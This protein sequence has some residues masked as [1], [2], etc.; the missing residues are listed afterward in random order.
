MIASVICLRQ[1]RLADCV[2][3]CMRR[4][5]DIRVVEQTDKANVAIQAIMGVL[6]EL[7]ICEDTDQGS[8]LDI[9]KASA[10]FSPATYFL[11][12]NT[13][14]DT[15][16]FLE[17]LRAGMNDLLT[18]EWTEDEVE[19]ALERFRSRRRDAEKAGRVEPAKSLRR[20]LDKQFFEDT[21]VTD[22][23]ATVLED[24]P[25]LEEEYQISFA[26]GLCQALFFVI[27]PR[28][29]EDLLA[30]A[31]LPML[32]LERAART[33]F[34]QQ[35]ETVVCYLKEDSLSVILNTA[36][37]APDMRQLCRRFLSECSR[38]LSWLSGQNTLSVGVGP[39]TRDF[40]M[41]PLEI[42]AAKFAAWM[43]LSEGKGR[44]LEYGSYLPRHMTK[45]AF[46]DEDAKAALAGP[47]KIAYGI[48][49]EDIHDAEHAGPGHSEP[50]SIKVAVAELLG[51]EYYIHSDFGGIDMVAK[52]PLTHEI[53]IGD[54]MK[55]TFTLG[56]AHIFDLRSENRIH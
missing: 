48:R 18:R 7:V 10:R 24:L 46:L 6:P 54:E 32:E 21:I 13:T 17:L 51:H 8:A 47:H 39:G 33:F 25:M 20:V 3:A 15:G 50:Y 37:T 9:L 45:E 28:P 4:N 16:E 31:F 30:E 34:G 36:G 12:C 35:F 14:P 11:V 2:S 23:G 42:Q 40:R 29:R 41:L 1:Q 52:I 53:K 5:P 22:A 27:D 55:L 49:P 44:V 38:T 26:K 19:R 56:K 43:R